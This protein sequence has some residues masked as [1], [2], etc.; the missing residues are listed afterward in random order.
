MTSPVSLTNADWNRAAEVGEEEAQAQTGAEDDW[1]LVG[2][3]RQSVISSPRCE[4]SGPRNPT[5]AN[6]S[7]RLRPVTSSN[8]DYW[9]LVSAEEPRERAVKK[10]VFYLGN[11]RQDASEESLLQYITQ[12]AQDVGSK[13][14]VFNSRLFQKEGSSAARITI[15]ANAAAFVGKANFWPRPVYVRRWKFPPCYWQH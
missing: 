14:S 3:T 11:L 15:N 5:Q 13:V 8:T 9:G 2:S 12:R 1:K 4:S 7:K 10:A 6:S